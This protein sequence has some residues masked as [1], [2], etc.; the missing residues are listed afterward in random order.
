M[1]VVVVGGGLRTNQRQERDSVEAGERWL[2][3]CPP[4]LWAKV[5]HAVKK[6]NLLFESLKI[7]QVKMENQK[8]QTAELLVYSSLFGSFSLLTT[9]TLLY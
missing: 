8:K 9:A 5:S 2:T 6:Q 7:L 3:G 4:C 1:V